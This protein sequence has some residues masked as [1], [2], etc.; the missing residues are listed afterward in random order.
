MWPDWLPWLLAA[1]VTAYPAYLDYRYREVPEHIWML[2]GQAG[3]VVAFLT[4]SRLYPPRLLGLWYL[5]GAAAPAAAAAGVLTGSLGP[6]DLWA[7]IALWLMVPAPPPG[8]LLPPPLLVV[9]WAAVLE[10]AARAAVSL[11]VCGGPGCLASARVPCR[12]LRDMRWWF[13]VGA[14]VASDEPSEA[15]A[16]ACSGR[17]GDYEVRARPGMPFVTFILIALPLAYASEA[18]IRVP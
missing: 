16:R 2:G 13:P 8:S 18:L 5:F 6:G 7:A 11:R 15:V 10:L 1:A 14:D 9:L 17:P 3:A 12:L 4:Y